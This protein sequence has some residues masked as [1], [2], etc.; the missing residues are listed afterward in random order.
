MP[1][2]PLQLWGH[3][4]V[5][6]CVFPEQSSSLAAPVGCLV[7]SSAFASEEKSVSPNTES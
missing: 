5:A 1:T 4:Q 3:F 7:P 6:L 2:L